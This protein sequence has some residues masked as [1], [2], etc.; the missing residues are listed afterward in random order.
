VLLVEHAGERVKRR[1][2]LVR[3]PLADVWAYSLHQRGAKK[4]KAAGRR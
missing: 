3:A 1:F 2:Q 4:D